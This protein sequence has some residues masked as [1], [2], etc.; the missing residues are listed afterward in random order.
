M[1]EMYNTLN[2]FMPLHMQLI[3]PTFVTAVVGMGCSSTSQCTDL[4]VNTNC[5]SLQCACVSGYTG[6][7]CSGNTLTSFK[8][9]KTCLTIK[10]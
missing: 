10:S 1:Q 5:S 8:R 9:S 4:L 2:I 7:T 6:T 3:V